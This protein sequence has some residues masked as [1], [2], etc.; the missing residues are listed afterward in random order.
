VDSDAGKIPRR[1]RKIAFPYFQST[2]TPKSGPLLITDLVPISE[3]CRRLQTAPHAVHGASFCRTSHRRTG[4]VSVGQVNW[5]M[6]SG[7]GVGRSYRTPYSVSFHRAAIPDW[8]TR[9]WPAGGPLA[10]GHR[11][12]ERDDKLFVERHAARFCDSSPAISRLYAARRRRFYLLF[13]Y[14]TVLSVETTT[15]KRQD[16]LHVAYL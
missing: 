16:R 3:P 14:K 8:R 13:T 11:D 9:R 6:S 4:D 12:G 1:T 7:A 2:N 10:D 5:P 15:E